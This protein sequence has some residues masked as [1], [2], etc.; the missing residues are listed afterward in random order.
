MEKGRFHSN[1]THGQTDWH[2]YN[3]KF[4]KAKS[5]LCSQAR[6]AMF[7]LL[8]KIRAMGLPID[9]QIHLFD[10]LV[11]PILLYA[12]EVWGCENNTVISQFQR[13][14]LKTILKCKPST[15][16]IMLYGELRGFSYWCSNQIKDVEFLV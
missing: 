11:C 7:S 14:F 12:S 1:K 13:K 4:A 15:P 6:K 3:G 2:N 9:I 10:T 16:N 5:H 8:T